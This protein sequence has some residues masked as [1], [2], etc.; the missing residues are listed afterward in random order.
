M[1]KG[2]LFKGD[3]FSAIDFAIGIYCIFALFLPLNFLNISAGAFLFIKG[4][5]SMFA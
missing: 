2:K 3:F 5:L 1:I 4:G